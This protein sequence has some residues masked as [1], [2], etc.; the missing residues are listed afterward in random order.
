M[1]PI[2]RSSVAA[3]LL[4]V[5]APRLPAQPPSTPAKPVV[6]VSVPDSTL[7]AIESFAKLQRV[8][9]TLRDREQAELAEPRNKKIDAQT[10][11]RARYRQLRADS[12]KAHGY[13][14]AQVSAMTLRLSGDDALRLLFETTMERLSK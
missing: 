13:T 10:D 9:N 11:I 4:V 1:S 8:I 14:P 6:P 7:R 5:G 3:L 12:L 2:H